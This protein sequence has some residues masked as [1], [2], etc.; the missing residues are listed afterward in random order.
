MLN[1]NG[2]DMEQILHAWHS[3]DICFDKLAVK[4]DFVG[5]FEELCL[6]VC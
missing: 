2:V 3:W 6:G 4:M 5:C 1:R